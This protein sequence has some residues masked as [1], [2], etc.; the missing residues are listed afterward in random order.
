MGQGAF[1]RR[2]NV[3]DSGA[4]DGHGVGNS[5]GGDLLDVARMLLKFSDNFALSSRAH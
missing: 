3:L 5:P 2:V 1:P 4:G